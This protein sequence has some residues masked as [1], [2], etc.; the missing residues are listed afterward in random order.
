[1]A[2]D[3]IYRSFSFIYTRPRKGGR[4]IVPYSTWENIC[5]VIEWR[6]ICIASGSYE[7]AT[8][9]YLS[10]TGH[11]KEHCSRREVALW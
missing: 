11:V 9:F 2:Q 4:L 8:L 6:G 5:P 10:T 1:M 7:P 3:Y